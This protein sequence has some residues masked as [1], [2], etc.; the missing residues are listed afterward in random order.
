M[1]SRHGILI[2]LAMSLLLAGTE[3]QV[4]GSP[5]ESV[6]DGETGISEPTTYITLYRSKHWEKG[7]L[8]MP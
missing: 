5:N 1:S 4:W 6:V 3:M 7:K 8:R 2:L